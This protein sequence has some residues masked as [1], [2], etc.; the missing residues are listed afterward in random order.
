[1]LT[2]K[3]VILSVRKDHPLW[4]GAALDIL[5]HNQLANQ[6]TKKEQIQKS[7][8]KENSQPNGEVSALP[9]IAFKIRGQPICSITILIQDRTF[10]GR[11]TAFPLSLLVWP[12]TRWLGSGTDRFGDGNRYGE[13]E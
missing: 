8:E 10:A 1:M 2:P 6:L 9:P 7:Q 13:E 12:A 3:K 11:G 4:P 5:Y